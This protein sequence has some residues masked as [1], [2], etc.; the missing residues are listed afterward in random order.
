MDVFIPPL[1][2][3]FDPNE[4]QDLLAIPRCLINDKKYNIDLE[5]FDISKIMT[6]GTPTPVV[7]C[8]QETKD[9]IDSVMRGLKTCQED[10]D[11]I[12]K[13]FINSNNLIEGVKNWK[14][15]CLDRIK[16]IN[17][18]IKDVKVDQTNLKYKVGVLD[19]D[20]NPLATKIHNIECQL[21]NKGL[22]SQTQKEMDGR[23]KRLESEV[24]DTDKVF[25]IKKRVSDLERDVFRVPQIVDEMMTKRD[26]NCTDLIME[27]Q[28]EFNNKI[29][30][31]EGEVGRNWKNYTDH[32]EKSV[33]PGLVDQMITKRDKAFTD[34]LELIRKQIDNQINQLKESMS[35][36]KYIPQD[37]FAKALERIEA[38]EK[39]SSHEFAKQYNLEK[40]VNEYLEPRITTNESRTSDIYEKIN[41][42]EEKVNEINRDIHPD[43]ERVGGRRTWAKF[44]DVD[45]HI[46]ALRVD[47]FEEIEELKKKV[48][49][50]DENIKG[51]ALSTTQPPPCPSHDRKMKLYDEFLSIMKG[52][53]SYGWFC[54]YCEMMA[55]GSTNTVM[56]HICKTN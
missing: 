45:K 5:P 40:R 55:F 53:N 3:P 9:Q 4:H 32:L 1:I 41:T 20:I 43:P 38:L 35:T 46:G 16:T 25:T 49:T 39:D 10:Y 47:A 44:E 50:H 34:L 28:K 12:E 51:L 19:N 31:L 23:I 22:C 21:E 24:Y 6:Q 42:I 7:C 18:E 29:Q 2:R 52:G 56:N 15:I 17:D 37:S 27:L 13:V 30:D 26:K 36:T 48:S 11:R 54:P 14:D 33:T 8:I